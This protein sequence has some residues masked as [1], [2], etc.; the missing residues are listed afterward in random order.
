MIVAAV[1]LGAASSLSAQQANTPARPVLGANE[2]LKTLV[3]VKSDAGKAVVR[4]GTGALQLVSVGDR[5]GRT[6]AVV[7]SVEPGRLVVDEVA[8][9]PDGRPQQTQII[10]KDG[11]R[12]GT[13]YRRQADQPAPIGVRPRAVEP[14]KPATAPPPQKPGASR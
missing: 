14:A 5:L 7:R 8:P 3:L 10:W 2:D 12:G 11:E 4:F 6:A 1:C 13:R 9:G